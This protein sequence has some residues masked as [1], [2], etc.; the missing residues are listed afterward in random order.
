[1]TVVAAVGFLGALFWQLR[2]HEGSGAE[3]RA[4]SLPRPVAPG[5]ARAAAA[6]A[7][8]QHNGPQGEEPA[9]TPGEDAA[10]TVV[11]EGDAD[12]RAAE[13]PK[14]RAKATAPAPPSAPP[15][16]EPTPAPTTGVV[17]VSVRPESALEVDGHVRGQTPLADVELP[18]GTHVVRL[19]HPDYWPLVRRVAVEAGG[20]SRVE[21]DLA[22]DA[23]PRG[24]GKEPP[25]RV[26]VDGSPYE[27][28]YF[29]RG[30]RHLSEGHFHDAF[31]TLEPVA[32]RLAQAGK[33]KERA[34]AEFYV[35]VALLEQGRTDEAAERF[36]R[37]LEHDG[38]LKLPPSGFSAKVVAAF[39]RER[40]ARASR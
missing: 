20:Q 9:A 32:R 3:A 19:T 1:L 4:T 36:A 30:L 14:L 23:V 8:A 27:D 5:P 28:P 7:A 16:T 33:A 24:R 10:A 40:E 12:Q 22:W 13:R 35:G 38:S 31:L 25:Y 39:T 29:M 26:P 37:A 15:V 34:R 17:T 18:P 2:E 11:T 6:P 21:V